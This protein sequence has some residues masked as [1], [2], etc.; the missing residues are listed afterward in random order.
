[1]RIRLVFKIEEDIVKIFPMYQI[2]LRSSHSSRKS[3]VISRSEK[4]YQG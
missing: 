3:L 4:G 1:M 2:E